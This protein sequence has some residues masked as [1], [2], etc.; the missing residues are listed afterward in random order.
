MPRIK[1]SHNAVLSGML[2]ADRLAAAIAAGRANDE[3]VEIENDWRASLIGKDLKRVRNVK[4][5]WS[6]FGTALGVALGGIDMWINQIFGTSPFTLKHGKTD[7]ASL[8]PAAKHQKI[9]YPKPD[10]VLTFDR[11]SSVFLSNTNHEE[12]QPIH[13]QLKNPELQKTSEL[14]VYAGPSTRYCPAGVYEWVEKDGK[15]V[16]VINAQNCVHCKTCDIKDPNQN[17]NWVPPQGGEGPVYPN[18]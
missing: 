14:D 12:D 2:A 11:L 3:P 6:K 1:G 10:G 9:D 15:D 5:L 8:E 4:P 7:A 13:L 17:I 16:F 18:M